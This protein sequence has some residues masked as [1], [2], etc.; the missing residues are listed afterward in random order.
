M[1]T[2]H[3][4]LMC[5]TPPLYMQYR[6]YGHMSALYVTYIC[7]ITEWNH[8]IWDTLGLY[9]VLAT[10]TSWIQKPLNT[11]QYYMTKNA[12]FVINVPISGIC[13]RGSTEYTDSICPVCSFNVYIHTWLATCT[14]G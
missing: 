12:V 10:E 13:N 8:S 6:L 9:I 7:D 3:L 2:H 14:L 5:W 4:I 1:Y 11:L